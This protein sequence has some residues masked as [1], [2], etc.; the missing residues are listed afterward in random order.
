MEVYT[1]IYKI[2]INLYPKAFPKQPD[3]TVW[4][5]SDS[6][7]S[8][9]SKLRA[10]YSHITTSG[11]SPVFGRVIATDN[12]DY[13]AEVYEITLALKNDIDTTIHVVANNVSDAVA[14]Y[15]EVYTDVLKASITVLTGTV[16][17]KSKRI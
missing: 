15:T 11:I 10:E 7:D 14:L 12:F 9:M 17:P 3:E 1:K 2:M 13:C 16:F 6:I 5:I 4:V 8:A